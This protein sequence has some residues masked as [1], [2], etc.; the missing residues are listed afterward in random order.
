MY[1]EI[2]KLIHD[3]MIRQKVTRERMGELLGVTSQAVTQYF[4]GR[5]RLSLPT[6]I[7]MCNHLGIR[8]DI[9][10]ISNDPD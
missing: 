6:A 9:G 4:S 1:E 2:L 8:I 3:E 5:V 7:T 10:G